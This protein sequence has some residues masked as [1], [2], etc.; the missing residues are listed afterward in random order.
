MPNQ[1]S[2]STC[3]NN[4]HIRETFIQRVLPLVDWRPFTKIQCKKSAHLGYLPVHCQAHSFAVIHP[5]LWTPVQTK[6]QCAY[7]NAQSLLCFRRMFRR[8]RRTQHGKFIII[9]SPYNIFR[10]LSCRRFSRRL[11][12]LL[13]LVAK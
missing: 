11:S 13:S 10:C 9:G 3:N 6:P 8:I 12:F 1:L 4:T 5:W 2:G 7:S